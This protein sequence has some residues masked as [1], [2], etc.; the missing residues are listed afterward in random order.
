MMTNLE[1]AAPSGW[2][3][4]ARWLTVL[5]LCTVFVALAM[6][7]TSGALV[8]DAYIALRYS[9][10]LA[11][12]AGLTFQDGPPVEGYTC[13]AWVVL[14]ALLE[15][16]GLSPAALL[17]LIGIGCGAAA[18]AVA[19]RA[20]QRWTSGRR[21]AIAGVVPGLF[22]ACSPGLAYYA[23]S[24]LETAPFALLV[25]LAIVASV[26]GRPT[27]TGVAGALA[28]LTRPEGAMV[29]GLTLV[30]GAVLAEPSRRRAWYFSG[31]GVALLGL[32]YAAFKWTYFGALLPN[33]AVA[34]APVLGQGLSYVGE[35]LIDAS[36]LLVLTGVLLAPRARALPKHGWCLLAAALL[37][38]IAIAEGGDWMSGN[39]L[40]L[41]ALVSAAPALDV[42]PLALTE[43]RPR[44]RAVLVLCLLPAL[45]L[46][47]Y[48]S[49]F[50]ARMFASSSASVASYEALRDDL[51][52][53]LVKS[54]A[55]SVG[56]L[57]IGRL[58]YAEPALRLFD[59]GGLTDAEVARLPGD[60]RSKQLPESLLRDRAPDAFLFAARRLAPS[61]GGPPSIDYHYPVEE[62]VAG[63]AW[64]R[65]HYRL[66]AVVRAGEGYFLCW[67][68]RAR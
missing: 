37:S 40:L 7:M 38:V 53:E 61:A 49:T 22:L 56:T 59:L 64:F 43:A 5:V 63:S 3:E 21:L 19:T 57:D 6:L 23:G 9:L 4:R 52:R 45:L 47:G 68:A 44:T 65:E 8:D 42:L 51:A 30:L 14:G 24:G 36:L 58:A 10:R 15:K 33:T 62:G 50:D 2:G 27:A 32:V 20:T 55:R 16:L 35:Q 17:P 1:A 28:L 46:L 31:A 18:V 60:Y 48:G 25:L 67:F 29:A 11:H 54:G 66:H 13:F 41:P 39:R 12:G 34:K 26:E